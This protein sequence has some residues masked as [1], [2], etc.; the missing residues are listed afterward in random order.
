MATDEELLQLAQQAQGVDPGTVAP[1]MPVAAPVIGTPEGPSAGILPPSDVPPAPVSAP[2]GTGV[3]PVAAPATAAP[4]V[5]APAPVSMPG[6]DTRAIDQARQSSNDLANAQAAKGPLI[7]DAANAE[8]E[9]QQKLA[10]QQ[11]N[12]SIELQAE[13]QSQKD[14]L[15]QA[16][17]VADQAQ[18]DVKN[19]KFADYW[20][21]RRGAD[22][23]IRP[24][25]TGEKI[26]ANIGYALGAYA[27]ATGNG[28]NYAAEK[29]KSIVD[30]DFAQQREMLHSKENIASYKERGVT[31]LQSQYKDDIARLGMKQGLAL[32]A[33]ADEA[34]AFLIKQSV[35]MKE[36][37]NN[38]L[39]AKIRN[40]GDNIYAKNFQEL[41]KDKAQLAMDKYRAGAAYAAVNEQRREHDLQHSDRETKEANDALKQV[42]NATAALRRERV[43][44]NI[45]EFNANAAKL[46]PGVITPEVLNKVQQNE[47]EMR[48][49]SEPHGLAGAIGNS[50]ARG[51]GIAAKS[52]Y[53]GLTEKQTEAMRALD[54]TMQHGAEMQPT[55]GAEVSAQWKQ[56]YRPR[57]DMTQ[58]DIDKSLSNIKEMGSTFKAIIDPTNIGGRADVG[59]QSTGGNSTGYP[60]AEKIKALSDPDRKDA[61]EATAALRNPEK[62]A[63]ARLFLQ[64]LGVM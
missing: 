15:A 61:I 59:K 1:S 42:G 34:R 38:E 56:T 45:H 44:A 10:D 32:K 31:D 39:V 17:K 11:R 36:A 16:R 3:P 50:V 27:A 52:P 29:I 48:A 22:G 60:S 2:D 41:V 28:H 9:T 12:D 8:A 26:R 24:T 55:T 14:G 21:T 57:P 30:Q 33:T 20:H 19:F 13:V 25:T 46:E 47:Q 35:P 6:I 4:V 54:A 23:E 53:S 58:A 7:A 64:S 40:E 5:P 49:M 51:I 62:S 18:E 63:K 43:A 37:D